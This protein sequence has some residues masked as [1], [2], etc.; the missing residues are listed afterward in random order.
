LL[1]PDCHT[2]IDKAPADYPTEELHRWKAEH[3]Q[4]VAQ[5]LPSSL[6]APLIWAVPHPV[7][8]LIEGRAAEVEALAVRLTRRPIQV[9]YGMPGVGK[10]QLAAHLARDHA[11]N[12]A[13]V[14]WLDGTTDFTLGRDLRRLADQLDVPRAVV[15]QPA[16]LVEAMR[17]WLGSHDDWLLIFDN[18]PGPEALSAL[19]P[20][21]PLGHVVITSTQPAWRLL[22]E[23]TKV[24]PLS[25]VSGGRYLLRRTASAD[26]IDAEALAMM[27]GGLPIALE[28]AAAYVETAQSTLAIYR[29]MFAEAAGA[30]LDAGPEP[31]DY[32]KTV[33]IT[34]R[35]AIQSIDGARRAEARSLLRLLSFCDAVRLPRVALTQLARSAP[36][37]AGVGNAIEANLTLAALASRSIVDLDV[38]SVAVHGVVAE[39]VRH[40]MTEDEVR[41][42]LRAAQDGMRGALGADDPQLTSTFDFYARMLPH[43]LAVCAHAQRVGVVGEDT[44]VLLD[45][46]ATHLRTQGQFTQAR[47]LFERALDLTHRLELSVGL[48]RGIRTNLADALIQIDRRLAREEMLH[49]LEDLGPSPSGSRDTDIAQA[50]VQTNLAFV[51]YLD[52][53]LLGADHRNQIA[54]EL[55]RSGYAEAELANAKGYIDAMNNRGLYAWASGR[56]AD[57]NEAWRDALRLLGTA[58]SPDP[59]Q[60][61]RPLA[62]LGV[63][64]EQDSPAE[65]LGLHLEAQDL[66]NRNLPIDHP[67][68]ISGLT[69]LGGAYRAVGASNHD[70]RYLR[71]A[72]EAHEDAEQAARRRYGDAHRHVA[73]AIHNQ[74]LDLWKSARLLEA[75]QRQRDA[76]EMF[77]GLSDVVPSDLM[78]GYVVLGR[79]LLDGGD[80]GGAETAFAAALAE[81]R[82][83]DL[84]AHHTQVALAHDGLGQVAVARQDREAAC[85]HFR[86][87]YEA[88]SAGAGDTAPST[89]SAAEKVR[90]WCDE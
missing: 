60:R 67:D 70:E 18:A 72:L 68:L 78:R 76:L 90:E 69:N 11:S 12:Y 15:E 75:E 54:V 88:F 16:A 79:I 7:N 56:T 74:S 64:V 53:D 87:A 10:S 61:A 26:T 84:P 19:L 83:S 1:C 21:A 41:G 13:V 20:E 29:I 46:A 28:Q 73:A 62:N 48:Q 44:V 77:R 59:L 17:R 82:A 58:R 23:P 27:L 9:L 39:V 89:H 42:W 49:L 3:E 81:W 36:Q 4:W 66:R 57:A 71:L 8:R 55:Y 45:R 33:S 50:N 65:A 63:L 37:P 86:R 25:P 24:E 22:A 80:V 43:V 2:L 35:L 51:M 30:M 38:E 14:W 85:R 6:R 34:V 52:G 5:S 32:G 47:E 31:A 40:E